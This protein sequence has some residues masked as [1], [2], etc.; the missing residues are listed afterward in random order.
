MKLNQN[1]NFMKIDLAS[2]QGPGAN[3][4]SKNGRQ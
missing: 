1:A 2:E 3:N 4:V